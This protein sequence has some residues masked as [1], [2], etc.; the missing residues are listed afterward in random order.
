MFRLSRKGSDN[1]CPFIEYTF[2][3]YL[4]ECLV[5]SLFL[6][7]L[8]GAGMARTTGVHLVSTCKYIWILKGSDH[9]SPI[10]LYKLYQR[11]QVERFVVLLF[12]CDLYEAGRAR[13]T[14]V[15]L[16]STCE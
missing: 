11:Y 13:T 2:Q 4:V 15:H 5:V 12:L 14:A 3:N 6:C 8:Y 16:L 9:M 7:D 1:R 10:S